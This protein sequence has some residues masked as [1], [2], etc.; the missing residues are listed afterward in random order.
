M[1][2][3]YF[4]GIGGISM[5]A[6]AIFLK[7]QGNEICGSDLN[8]N[9]TLLELS[10]Y[11]I[12]FYI[13]HK[14]ENIEAFS[15]DFVVINSAIFQNNEELAFAK[16]NKIKILSRA[17][18]LAQISK[19]FKNV[20]AI[21][22]THG[23]TTT[24]GMISEIFIDANFKPTVHIGGILAKTNSNYII[25][26]NKFFITEAC[27]YKNNFLTLR[28]KLGVMLNLE[29]DHMDFF[30]DYKDLENSFDKFLSY[31]KL[32]IYP[33]NLKS[34]F[35]YIFQSNTKFIE[36]YADKIIQTKDGIKFKYYEN[37]KYIDDF[38]LKTF[39]KHNVNNAIVAIMTAR[40]FKI[41]LTN[42]KRGLRNYSGVK[43]R[44][45]KIGFFSTTPIIHDY[46]HHPTEI[47][48]VILQAKTYGKVLTIFQPHT[49]S[50]TKKL[51]KDFLKCFDN[52]D[53]LFLYKTYPAREDENQGYSAKKLFE[54]LKIDN[55][56]E[57]LNYFE[58]EE[59]LLKETKKDCSS[60]NIVL[61]LGAG[62]IDVIAKNLTK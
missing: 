40:H 13:G 43:R 32:K 28:P 34:E 62:N 26:E 6:L 21:S 57:L 15:P 4:I 27:E 60:Y 17:K 8:N 37:G 58:N 14:K 46:A 36:F 23:K 10:K 25:G 49:F 35:H 45:E 20:I 48:K 33:K 9:E 16:K 24:V 54:N 11:S 3:Y 12:P 29:K 19:K 30:K 39:G 56:F 31:S 5:S 53:A 50:R 38:S 55:N 47:K 51:F 41:K 2:K 1:A 7:C 42:I 52:T 44:F 61:V 59:E 18:V 22:G